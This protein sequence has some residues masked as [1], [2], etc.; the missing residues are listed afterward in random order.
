MHLGGVRRGEERW[1]GVG[2]GWE[3]LGGDVKRKS[4]T[5]ESKIVWCC[6]HG[7]KK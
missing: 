1:G 4:C 2:R 3:G 5:K 6:W 7:C